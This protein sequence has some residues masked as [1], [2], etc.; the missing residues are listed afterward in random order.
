MNRLD[1]ISI[2]VRIVADGGVSAAAQRMQ[3]SKSVVSRR[4]RALEHRLGVALLV[5]TTR[6]QKLTDEGQRFY[7]HCA[8]ALA[9]LEEAEAD[10]TQADGE[11]T[12]TLRI[13]A[14]VYFG[15]YFLAPLI[16]EFASQHPK[17]TVEIDLTDQHVNLIEQGIDIAVRLGRLNDSTLRARKLLTVPHLVGASPDYLDRYGV[18]QGPG[19]L[20]GH[21]GLMH[22][23]GTKPTKWVYYNSNGE[24]TRAQVQPAMLSNNDYLLLQAAKLGQGLLYMPKFVIEEALNQGDLVPV[25]SEVAWQ[26]ADVYAVYPA[27]RHVPGRIRRFID[28]LVSAFTAKSASQRR[29]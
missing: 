18:P 29:A 16:S 20:Q 9:E 4:L 21:R 7:E 27:A 12:G 5:R 3:L 28:L 19:V 25:L 23:S 2:F 11:L 17:L 22:R 10:L 8:R 26:G 13:T 24:M 6:S 15:Q 14:S 1:D